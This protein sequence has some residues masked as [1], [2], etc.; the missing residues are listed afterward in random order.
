MKISLNEKSDINIASA[1]ERRRPLQSLFYAHLNGILAFPWTQTLHK[2]QKFD[3]N[4]GKKQVIFH[5]FSLF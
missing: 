2:N 1:R 5:L 3:K 4:A